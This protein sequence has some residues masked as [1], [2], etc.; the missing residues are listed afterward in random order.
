MGR[1][2]EFYKIFKAEFSGDGFAIGFGLIS[3]YF[4]EDKIQ[5]Y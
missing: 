5:K 3:H 2:R 4:I 1:W